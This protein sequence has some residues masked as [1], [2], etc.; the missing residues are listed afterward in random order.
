[1]K[2][3]SLSLHQIMAKLGSSA[4][5]ITYPDDLNESASGRVTSSI[6]FSPELRYWINAQAD[7]LGISFQDF[8]SLTMQGVQ[9]CTESPDTDEIDTM[10]SRFFSLFENSKIP[11]ADIPKI[12]SSHPIKVS[13][14]RNT[15]AIVDYLSND[16]TLDDLVRIF[17]VNRQWLKGCDTHIYKANGYYKNLPAICSEL[18]RHV[19]SSR[20]KPKVYLIAAP[21]TSLQSV[22]ENRDNQHGKDTVYLIPLIRYQRQYGEHTIPAYQLWESLAWDYSQ[23]RKHLKSLIYFC[24]QASISIMGCTV[25]SADKYTDITEGN[26]LIPQHSIGSAW[27]ID[28][29]AWGNEENPELY[30]LAEIKRYLEEEGGE[31]YLKACVDS[32]KVSNLQAFIDTGELPEFK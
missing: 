6:R 9:T 28:K 11:V 31:P 24:E 29:L 14:L 7:H 20:D 10:V 22:I 12:L 26:V 19:V 3:L 32:Y 1:M 25:K 5:K 2:R 13:Q 30:E 16:K 23:T 17:G 4:P 21:G 18:S 8:V 27:N 15:E